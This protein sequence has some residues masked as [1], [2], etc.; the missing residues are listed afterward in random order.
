MTSNRERKPRSANPRRCRGHRARRR[1]VRSSGHR[2]RGRERVWWRIRTARA[3]P[4]GEG[5]IKQF[6]HEAVERSAEARG[7]ARAAA[8]AADDRAPA[9]RPDRSRRPKVSRSKS[10]RSSARAGWRS[11]STGIPYRWYF[12]V[13]RTGV[14][15]E[16]RRRP[17]VP[18][19][20]RLDAAAG[21]DVSGSSAF[22]GLSEL[23]T[24][25]RSGET[26]AIPP[27]SH[28]HRL[29]ILMD[30]RSPRVIGEPA[31][32]LLHRRADTFGASGY[33]VPDGRRLCVFLVCPCGSPD[34][35]LRHLHAP[36]RRST[37][38]DLLHA[39]GYRE[40]AAFPHWLAK[41]SAATTTASTSSSLRQRHGAGRRPWFNTPS[42]PQCS[43][44]TTRLCPPEEYDL[45]EGVRAGAG[46]L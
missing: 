26:P 30:T 1:C 21:T 13:T 46:A 41:G 22:R 44:M 2:H 42:R 8:D 23:P 33:F 11:R 45:V 12:T 32:R 28:P 3:W 38:T 5:I 39:V 20:Q 29:E 35:R 43:D 40:R 14:S 25:Q 4:W 15:S 9:L 27:A 37:R 19:L 34:E 6:V 17:A 31:Y 10:T 24:D 36:R 18:C 16:G 7:R